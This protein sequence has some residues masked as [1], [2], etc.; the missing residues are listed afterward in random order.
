MGDRFTAG[1]QKKKGG[2]IGCSTRHKRDGKDCQAGLYSD[3]LISVAVTVINYYKHTE[4]KVGSRGN[5]R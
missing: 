3:L 4:Y 5:V 1:S 2:E